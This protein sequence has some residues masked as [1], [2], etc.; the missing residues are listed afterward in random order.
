[1]LNSKALKYLPAL[2]LGIFSKRVE[3]G[4]A[5]I[6]G[7]TT[8]DTVPAACGDTLGLAVPSRASAYAAMN[9][10]E[11]GRPG[12]GMALLPPRRK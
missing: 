10:L 9:S 7:E 1:V 3:A 11:P 8:A 6:G 5:E 4:S 2:P 12:K